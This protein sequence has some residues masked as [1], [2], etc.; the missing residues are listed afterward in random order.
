MKKLPYCQ[1]YPSEKC[2][3]NI[4]KSTNNAIHIGAKNGYKGMVKEVLDGIKKELNN[5]DVKLCATGGS[6]KWFKG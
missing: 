6:A 5:G 3:G 2:N 4:G 1:I